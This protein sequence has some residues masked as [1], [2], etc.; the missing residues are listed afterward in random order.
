MSKLPIKFRVLQ[1]INQKKGVTNE[2]ILEILKFEYPRD[3]V[4]NYKDI[5]YYLIS[6]KSVGLIDSIS[7]TLRDHSKLVESYKISDYG[8]NR[9]KYINNN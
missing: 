5:E 8:M 4:V 9:M 3:R 6:L 1:L 7:V 2:E